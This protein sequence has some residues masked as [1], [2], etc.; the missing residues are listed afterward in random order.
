MFDEH[1]TGVGDGWFMYPRQDPGDEAHAMISTYRQA[2][3]EAG[4]EPDS[5]GVNATVFANQGAGPDEWRSIDIL[6]N[7]AGSD[8]GGRQSFD[9]GRIDEWVGTID[10]NVSGLMRVTAAFISGMIERGDGHIV[11][12]G[13]TQGLNGAPGCAAYA[14]S[15]HAVHGFSE[16]LRQ[17]YA[18]KGIRVSEIL[19]G[20]VRTGFAATRFSDSDRGDAFYD[21]YG[22]CLEAKDIA[23]CIMFALEQPP[24]AVIAQMVVAPDHD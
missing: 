7:N 19:P 9:Q 8:V 21:A 22:Q 2:A 6:V 10:I 11:N 20:M 13:S 15:K 14:A 4:R 17:E 24:H 16:T 12:L 18:G 23:R 1:G 5:L 3:A